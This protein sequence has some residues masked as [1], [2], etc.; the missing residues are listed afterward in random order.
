MHFYGVLA[1]S[2][3]GCKTRVKVNFTSL[4]V[5]KRRKNEGARAAA[6]FMFFEAL[7]NLVLSLAKMPFPSPKRFPGA[8]PGLPLGLASS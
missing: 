5:Q 4:F 7:K 3:N 6:F 1:P 8:S 2:Q